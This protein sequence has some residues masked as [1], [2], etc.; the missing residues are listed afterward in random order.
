[1]CTATQWD[2]KVVYSKVDHYQELRM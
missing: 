2:A 1:L